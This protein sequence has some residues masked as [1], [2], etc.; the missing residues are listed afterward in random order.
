MQDGLIL[1]GIGGFYYVKSGS[2]IYECKARGIFRKDEMSPVPGDRV[3]IDVLEEN[4]KTGIIEEIYYRKNLLIRPPVANVDQVILVF[5]VKSPGPDFLLLDK[6]LIRA[7]SLDIKPVICVNKIDL[8]DNGS[9]AAAFEGYIKAGYEVI[10]VSAQLRIGIENLRGLLKGNITI[11][12][13]PSGV[14]KSTLINRIYSEGKAETGDISQ[15][16]ERGKHT[17]RQVE[18]Y[19]VEGGGYI[20]DTPGFSSFSIDDIDYE[21]LK[22]YYP[23]FRDHNGRCRFTGCSHISEPSCSVKEAIEEGRISVDRYERY[24]QLYGFLKQI[25]KY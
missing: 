8:D 14:G 16:I 9:T 19:E 23:E 11:L 15:K 24:K 18:M 20:A 5:A 21:S 3:R 10:H 22:E 17:T 25:R 6:L 4:S 2:T 13:G 1:K 12:A 7:V